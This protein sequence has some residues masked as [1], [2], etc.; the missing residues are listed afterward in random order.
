MTE[1]FGGVGGEVGV[2]QG[3][4][5][6]EVFSKYKDNLSDQRVSSE[7]FLST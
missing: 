3:K 4:N 7:K 1:D 5:E 2:C 6:R